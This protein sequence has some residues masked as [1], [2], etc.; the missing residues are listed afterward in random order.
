M[1]PRRSRDD[2]DRLR[3]TVSSS[4][5]DVLAIEQSRDR[6]SDERSRQHCSTTSSSN[7][8]LDC[9]RIPAANTDEVLPAKEHRCIPRW[10]RDGWTY[11]W[12]HGEDS[13]HREHCHRYNRECLIV[14]RDCRCDWEESGGTVRWRVEHCHST[15]DET[16]MNESIF[17]SLHLPGWIVGNWRIS[18]IVSIEDR[19]QH[20]RTCTEWM[21]R[22]SIG[23]SRERSVRDDGWSFLPTRLATDSIDTEKW[24]RSISNIDIHVRS[25]FRRTF[26][27]FWKSL[28]CSFDEMR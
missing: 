1:F 14:E 18:T 3:S 8:G 13:W 28:A 4:V 11:L 9:W 12:G 22:R 25:D 5:E 16:D 27:M 24:P 26:S 7:N 23:L 21:L 19:H 20:S 2:F 6:R 15:T 10:R 17:S